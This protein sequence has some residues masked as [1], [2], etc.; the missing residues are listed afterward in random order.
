MNNLVEEDCSAK[1]ITGTSIPGR[2][3]ESVAGPSGTG[4]ASAP[5]PLQTFRI[6]KRKMGEKAEEG[7]DPKRP[8]PVPRQKGNV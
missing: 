1:E 4:S 5:Q 8:K 2:A 7:P 6:V 3:E